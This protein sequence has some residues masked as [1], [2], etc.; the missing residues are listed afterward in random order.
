MGAYV[1]T[2]VSAYWNPREGIEIDDD[3][4]RSVESAEF[5]PESPTTRRLRRAPPSF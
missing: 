1:S 5:E 3:D 2:W 4:V